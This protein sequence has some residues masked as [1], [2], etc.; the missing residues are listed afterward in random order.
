VCRCPLSFAGTSAATGPD[1]GKTD[2]AA[3]KK[4][5]GELETEL[6]VALRA[7]EVLK[8]ETSPKGG[9]RRSR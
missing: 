9:T 4:R 5:I 1:G 2:L 3:A 7:V 6:M 8:A